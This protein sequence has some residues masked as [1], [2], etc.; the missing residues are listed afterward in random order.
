MRRSR[1]PMRPGYRVAVD[2]D[3]SKLFVTT[4]DEGKLWVLDRVAGRR[5]GEV[6]VGAGAFDLVIVP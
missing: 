5:A 4:G 2:P 3:G 6:S 1:W